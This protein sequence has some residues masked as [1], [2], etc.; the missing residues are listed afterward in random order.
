MISIVKLWTRLRNRTYRNAFVAAQLKHGVPFQIRAMRKQRGWS[1]QELANRSE[2]PQGTISRA[3]NMNYGDLS[4][5][6]V[7]RIANGFDV[8][9]V[10]RFVPFSELMRWYTSLS[11]ELYVPTFEEE[12]AERQERATVAEATE[13]PTEPWIGVNQ[14]AFRAPI[15]LQVAQDSSW[16]SAGH[17]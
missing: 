7:L 2:V 14:G 8:A 9:F 4:F 1:Q 16:M 15:P 6:T 13:G 3:E 17:A 5:N 11:D 10:G 12:D